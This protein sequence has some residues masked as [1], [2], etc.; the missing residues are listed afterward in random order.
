LWQFRNDIYHQDNE[1]KIARYKLEDLE[2]DMEKLW[3]RHIELLPKL[4][5]F[6]K[7]HFDRRQPIV[8]LRYESKK[9]WATLAKLYLDE[10]E[11]NRHGSLSN[12]DQTNG[13]RTGVG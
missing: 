10:A 2:R 12:I 11:S 4:W 13:L 1:G 7:Q 5:D 9:C 6:Q 3:A 8:D